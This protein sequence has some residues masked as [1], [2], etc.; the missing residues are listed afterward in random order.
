MNSVSACAVQFVLCLSLSQR[1]AHAKDRVRNRLKWNTRDNRTLCPNFILWLSIE[2]DN[3]YHFPFS[4][5]SVSVFVVILFVV[6]GGQNENRSY[7]TS[8]RR[9]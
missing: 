3:A 5:L 4:S 9:V 7:G 1:S 6:C 2:V 8:D